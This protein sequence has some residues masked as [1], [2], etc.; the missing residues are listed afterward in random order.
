MKSC[1]LTSGFMDMEF[2]VGC[3]S[4]RGHGLHPSYSLHVV[5]DLNYCSDN[6]GNE[7]TGTTIFTIT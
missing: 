4:C 3:M 5:L 1:C 6:D 7:T 2:A